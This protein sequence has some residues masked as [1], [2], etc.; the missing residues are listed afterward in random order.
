MNSS[1]AASKPLISFYL[2]DGDHNCVF[3][4]VSRKLSIK[5]YDLLL[6]SAQ[7]F[8]ANILYTNLTPDSILLFYSYVSFPAAFL[9]I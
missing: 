5:D 9:H 7:N 4:L 8:M 3:W 6:A 2:R 1:Y